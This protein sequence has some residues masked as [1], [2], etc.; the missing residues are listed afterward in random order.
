MKQKFSRQFDRTTEML[1]LGLEESWT[2]IHYAKG[3]K[4]KTA[5]V[6]KNDDESLEDYLEKFFK[7]NAVSDEI[8][9]DV[10]KF[11]KNEENLVS[12][13]WK[14]FTNFLMKALSLHM[15]FGVAI[16][17]AIYGGY[18]L[19]TLLDDRYDI[20]PLFTAIGFIAGIAIGGLV[21]YTMVIK[22]FKSPSKSANGKEKDKAKD[23]SSDLQKHPVIDVSIDD[24][25]QAVRTFSDQLPKGVYRTILVNDDNSVD[26]KQL[27][28]ILGGIPSKK[29]YMSKE[30]YDLFEEK[31]KLIPY[32]MDLVQKAV[33]QY[34]K[35]QRQYPMLKFDPLHRVNYFQLI[36]EHYLK[37]PPQTQFYIT[38]LD[39][40]ITHIK[41]GK[42]ATEG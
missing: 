22:Y 35:E 42:K 31:D 9:K 1:E 32:E 10:R 8:K 13:N 40:L 30:T 12:S 39:G 41:P 21:A 36:Q 3:S 26:F 33:D 34:V 15:V 4:E 29:F 37:S 6:L 23:S 38:D 20:Y 16:A 14:E 18:R 27:V 19:G 7:E 2:Y 24:V 5:C 11:L 28:H 25:R 17:L